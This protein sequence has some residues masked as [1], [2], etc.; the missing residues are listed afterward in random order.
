M[1][2][3]ASIDQNGCGC[4]SNGPMGDLIAIDDAIS[5][6]IQNVSQ[7]AETE[8]LAL[9]TAQGRILA[10]PVCAGRAVPPFDTSAMD[11]FAIDT[12]GL[13]GAGPW[14]LS[15][16]AR[17]AAGQIDHGTLRPG[18]AAQ[19][20]T[21]APIPTGA[22]AVVM[23]EDVQFADG[24][25]LISRMIG[26]G[27][28]IRTAGEDM[29]T[30]QPVVPAGRHLTARDIAA[31]AA[32]GAETVQVRRRVRVA[33]LVTG[34]EVNMP[35]Q[36]LQNAAIRDVNTPMLCATIAMPAIE[37]VHVETGKDDREILQQQLDEL[38]TRVDLVVTTGGISVGEEDHVKPALIDL[39]VKMVFSGVAM[40]PGKPVSF[41]RLG[42][43]YW[44]GLPGN[45]LS[46]FVT[47]QLFGTVL[48]RA[49]AGDRT[50]S[51]PRRHVVLSRQLD[52]KYGRCELRLAE[53]SG[54]DGWGREVV[55]FDDATHS[56]RVARLPAAHGVI[57]IPAEAETLL[58]GA[59]VEFQPFS[60]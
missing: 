16:T 24:A 10:E 58:E 56:G 22:D 5:R 43:A 9:A 54:F 41:G 44:L 59:L 26:V 28:H 53:L 19:I 2:V 21:G 57:M 40:K 25:I 60:D 48:C 27:A 30:G 4:G 14:R 18:T 47:W 23:Q 36:P 37:L 50:L 49:L 38:A 15:V 45:P 42:Q 33:L 34:D 51:S 31:C 12:A 39:G 11:G 7:V 46:A 1:T 6:I 13:T 3:L 52:H 55:H 29:A 17:I 35:G 8:E 20:F 32:A